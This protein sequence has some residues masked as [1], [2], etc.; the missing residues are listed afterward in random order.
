M[1]QIYASAARLRSSGAHS[2][3]RH[4]A[5]GCGEQP[6]PRVVFWQIVAQKRQCGQ[7]LMIRFLPVLNYFANLNPSGTMPVFT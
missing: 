4:E 2:C 5:I 3:I 1:M 6:L 7:N